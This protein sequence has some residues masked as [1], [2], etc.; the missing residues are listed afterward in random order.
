MMTG[1]SERTKR[2]IALLAGDDLEAEQSEEIRR[3][4]D[5]C[6]DCRRHWLRVRGCLDVL[7]RAGKANEPTPEISLWP[8]LEVRLRPAS[9]ARRADKFNGWIPALSMAAA[10]IALLIAGQRDGVVPADAAAFEE[11]RLFVGH[12]LPLHAVPAPLEEA[13]HYASG[14]GEPSELTPLD[15]RLLVQ[16]RPNYRIAPATF[17]LP[18]R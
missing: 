1:L 18:E 13:T 5:A 10:C 3:S 8:A 6:P 17:S 7:E 15:G 4:V 9:V 11:H 2:Q 14:S 16:P 12:S